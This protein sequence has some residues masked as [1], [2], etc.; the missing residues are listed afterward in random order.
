MLQYLSMLCVKQR[1]LLYC[2]DQNLMVDQSRNFMYSIGEYHNHHRPRYHH[3]Y[4]I[5]VKQLNYSTQ[6]TTW[7]QKHCI[8]FI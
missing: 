5:L 4:L 6:S 8:Y 1:L 3:P 7:Y 2:G